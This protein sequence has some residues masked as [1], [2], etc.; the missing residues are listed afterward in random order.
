MTQQLDV[1]AEPLSRFAALSEK[2]RRAELALSTHNAMA[3][4]VRKKMEKNLLES[5][6]EVLA[7]RERLKIEFA[8][9]GAQ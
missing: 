3:E 6:A 8:K 4:R 9:L 1:G 2:L 5:R 7:E